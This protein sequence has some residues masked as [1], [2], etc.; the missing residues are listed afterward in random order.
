M[1]HTVNAVFGYLQIADNAV[2]ATERRTMTDK[3]AIAALLELAEAFVSY[4]EDD[5]RSQRR[6]DECLRQARDLIQQV[7]GSEWTTSK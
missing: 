6:R 2:M 4:L 3:E 5:S 1:I 7:K